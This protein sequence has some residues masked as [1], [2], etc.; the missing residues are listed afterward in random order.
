M[1]CLLVYSPCYFHDRPE[2][3]DPRWIRYFTITSRLFAYKAQTTSWP[4]PDYNVRRGHITLAHAAS[5][6]HS[7]TCSF[8]YVHWPNSS[9]AFG[10]ASHVV[11]RAEQREATYLVA[12]GYAEQGASMRGSERLARQSGQD[13]GH[14]TDGPVG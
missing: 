3:L 14:L 6:L 13:S 9:Q 2:I 10:P 5:D 11:A 7:S 4:R 1:H 12:G 8:W